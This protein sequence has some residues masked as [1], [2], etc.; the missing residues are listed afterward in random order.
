MNCSWMASRSFVAMTPQA[1]AH[2]ADDLEQA[3]ELV[4]AI[5]NAEIQAK[6]GWN[7]DGWKYELVP[8]GVRFTRR[9]PV[10]NLRTDVTV[11]LAAPLPLRPATAMRFT[12]DAIDE[13]PG[14]SAFSN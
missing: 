13:S 11:H 4:E 8:W 9:D 6:R 10:R 3:A 5:D 1:L 2:L 12:R 14:Q 7:L